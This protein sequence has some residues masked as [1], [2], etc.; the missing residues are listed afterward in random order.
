[1]RLAY[2]NEKPSENAAAIAAQIVDL[3]ADNAA[4]YAEADAALEEA[5]RQLLSDTK[6]VII[7][8]SRAGIGVSSEA[9]INTVAAAIHGRLP[10]VLKRIASKGSESE[11]RSRHEG[12]EGPQP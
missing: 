8:A 2:T 7:R 11:G 4:N 12:P 6:P 10:E 5:Q 9:D 1:M 3:L